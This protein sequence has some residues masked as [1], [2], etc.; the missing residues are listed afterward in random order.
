MLVADHATP[1][2]ANFPSSYVR[3][4]DRAGKPLGSMD[5]TPMEKNRNGRSHSAYAL[6]VDHAVFAI[7]NRYQETPHP[8]YFVVESGESLW[9]ALPTTDEAFQYNLYDEVPADLM[10]S[11]QPL[12]TQMESIGQIYQ[13]VGEYDYRIDMPLL[14]SQDPGLLALALAFLINY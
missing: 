3:F 13:G 7:L 10:T 1:W 4:A 2:L 11:E 12:Q 8:A 14:G 5:M 6:V 9:V